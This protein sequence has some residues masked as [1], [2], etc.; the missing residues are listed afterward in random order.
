[1]RQRA[2]P[3]SRHRYARR[4]PCADRPHPYRPGRNPRRR[5]DAVAEGD[6]E[7]VD[8][9]LVP[10]SGPWL[11]LG[12][13]IE[14]VRTVRPARAFPIHDAHF[15]DAGLDT[16][17]WWLDMKGGDRLRQYRR[18][19]NSSAGSRRTRAT[20]A[21]GSQH[22]GDR[23]A[24]KVGPQPT[25][26]TTIAWV[27]AACG[28]QRC[29]V[30]LSDLASGTDTQVAAPRGVWANIGAFSPDGRYLAVVFG[31]VDATGPA[32]QVRVGVIDAA[33]RRLLAVSGA[34][35]GGGGDFWL[36]V[37][38]SPDGAWLLL[39]APAGEQLAAWRPGDTV[40]HV[41]RRQPPTGQHL[42]PAAG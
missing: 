8:T 31:G 14:F 38:W 5:R 4:Q 15:N 42:A 33:T 16:F 18:N 22:L 2:R 29:P 20:S 35:M 10:A 28:P 32:T 23:V 39:S 37:T 11:K 1:M 3:R 41:P 17:D 21:G 12:E 34:V 30:H 13:A 25:T 6:A 26:A 9:L 7:A 36:A 40:L 19:E 24:G 27:A